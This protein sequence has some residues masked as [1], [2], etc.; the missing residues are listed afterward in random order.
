MV[1]DAVAISRCRPCGRR[2]DY[3]DLRSD[4]LAEIFDRGSG[5][6]L[7]VR[8]LKRVE[9]NLDDT[10]RAQDHRRIDMAHMGDAERL[11]GEVA[12]TGA[13]H[14]AAFFLAVALQRGRIGAV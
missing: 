3:N 2:D 5:S 12:D 4:V 14:H 7:A 10:E 11:A 8:N 13:E 1:R 9:A 6:A